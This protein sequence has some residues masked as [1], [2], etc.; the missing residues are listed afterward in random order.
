MLAMDVVDTLRHR[1]Q[2]VYRELNAEA[3]ESDLVG[4]LKEIYAAQGIDVPDRILKDGVK[5][6][7]EQRFVYKA[8]APSLCVTL[9]KLYVTRDRWG[10]IAAG[11]AGALVA[12]ALAW[13]FLLVGPRE[14]SWARMPIELA[15]ARDAAVAAST[16]PKATAE[17]QAIYRSAMS[18]VTDAKRA[19]ARKELAQLRELSAK[20]NQE[21][22]VR[23]VN[24][25]G[26]ASGVFRIPNDI[27]NA[28][29]YYLIVEAVAPGGKV[30]TVPVR[31]EEDQR[32]HTVS[33]WA[34]RVTQEV[35]NRVA[36]DKRNNQI[37]E[38]DVL[39]FK[40][41]GKLEPDYNGAAAGGAIVKW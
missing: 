9:A 3:R 7:D 17:A 23:I 22:E 1:A 10:A 40:A 34:Q 39:G 21:Y 36:A 13:Q 33:K 35:Y 5:A 20:L 29:N 11:V 28:R 19:E 27:P 6:L 26:E 4:R 15:A 8:P 12:A 16:D 18:D 30:L 2:M 31:S 14:A 25:P 24:R 37:I 38:N 32:V 41:R